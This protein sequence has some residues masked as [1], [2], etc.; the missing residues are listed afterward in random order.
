MEANSSNG[1]N[2]AAAGGLTEQSKVQQPVQPSPAQSRSNTGNRTL[3]ARLAAAAPDSPRD[4]NQTR[5]ADQSGHS[6]QSWLTNE[7]TV[8]G[9]NHGDVSCWCTGLVERLESLES[10][11]TRTT[12]TNLL[13]IGK[14]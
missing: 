2:G 12:T 8:W 9:V 3:G 4:Q 5:G 1:E 10:V 6:H 7:R 14:L 13:L 11:Q